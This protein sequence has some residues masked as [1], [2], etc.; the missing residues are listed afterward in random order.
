MEQ[1][2]G[3]ERKELFQEAFDVLHEEVH[4]KSDPV[5]GWR[6]AN[7][8]HLLEGFERV[9]R[10]TARKN[11]RPAGILKLAVEPMG[12]HIDLGLV[13]VNVVTTTGV[14]FVIDAFQNT[15]EVETIKY[16]GNGTGNTAAVIGDTT[17]ETEVDSRSTGTTAEGGSANIY[18]SVG[19]NTYSTTR[20]I[21][22]HGIFSVST[23][24][25][26]FDRSVF[27]AINTDT[28]TNIEFTYEWTLNSGG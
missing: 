10:D 8:H 24:G 16:H 20:A 27:T 2:V 11:T 9:D 14:N 13:S 1:K 7:L 3:G 17:L 6:I 5:V 18:Q 25:T 22:E 21:V 15:E 23:S 19:T 28:S 26:L 4:A 12:E